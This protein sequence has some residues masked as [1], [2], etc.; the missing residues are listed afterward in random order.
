MAHAEEVA[1]AIEIVRLAFPDEVD[2][3][4][5]KRVLKTYADAGRVVPEATAEI[6]VLLLT[7]THPGHE[8]D[9]LQRV[10]VSIAQHCGP[11]TPGQ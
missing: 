11:D 8:A 2:S 4:R 5:Y 10:A 9:T 1:R 7:L 6:V 3:A